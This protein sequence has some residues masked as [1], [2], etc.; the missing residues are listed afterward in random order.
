VRKDGKE[1]FFFSTRSGTVGG[2]DL[3]TSTRQ[4][5]HDDWS[6]PANVAALNTTSNDQTPSLSFDGHTL[7]FASNR[8]GSVG[9][10]IWMTMRTSS[11]DE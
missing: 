10:D 5:V 9:N 4:N 11:G 1:I 3:W 2:I 7:V 6:E 8:P